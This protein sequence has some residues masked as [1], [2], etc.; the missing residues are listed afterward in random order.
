MCVCVSVPKLLHLQNR[1]DTAPSLLR[2][3]HWA[4]GRWSGKPPWSCVAHSSSPTLLLSLLS[5]PSFPGLTYFCM[6]TFPWRPRETF[7]TPS[8]DEFGGPIWGIHDALGPLD[9]EQ[10]SEERSDASW[11]PGVWVVLWTQLRPIHSLETLGWVRIS[12]LALSPEQHPG[13]CHVS[14]E[15]HTFLKEE[16]GGSYWQRKQET[17]PILE[18]ARMGMG[19]GQRLG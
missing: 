15:C 5:K 8:R 2:R 11:V 1:G 17:A 4:C 16:F 9:G 14:S 6:R 7:G 10:Y 18:D 13:H 19:M 3:S 12:Q